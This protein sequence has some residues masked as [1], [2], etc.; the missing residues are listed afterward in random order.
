MVVAVA[1]SIF[2][3]WIVCYGE[4]PL[5]RLMTGAVIL[6]GGVV[7]MHY[8]GMAALMFERGLSGTGTG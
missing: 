7:A 5:S 3:L 1:A 4:L 2:A 8:I 6:A